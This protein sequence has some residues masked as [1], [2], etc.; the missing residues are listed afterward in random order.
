MLISILLGTLYG[1]LVGIVPAVG[2]TVGLSLLFGFVS[3][4]Q[5][6]P[7]Q[8]LAFITAAVAASTTADSYSSILIGVPGANSSAATVIDGYAMTKKGEG[9]RAFTAAV[10]TSTLSGVLVGIATFMLLPYF[11][12]L[13]EHISSFIIWIVLMSSVTCIAFLSSKSW[14]KNITV[15]I[16]AFIVGYIGI[17]PITN[18]NRWTFGWD[19]LA[20]GIQLLPVVMGLFAIPEC[21]ELYKTRQR[22]TNENL[23]SQIFIGMK[24]IFIHWKDAVR[25]S[26]IGATIG[27]I[28]G[29][30][31]AV[32]DWISYS[33]T[34]ASNKNDEFGNGNVKGVIGIEGSNNAQKATSLVPTLLFGIPG[35]SFA[36]IYLALLTFIGFEIG[37]DTILYDEEFMNTILLSFI[38]ATLIIGIVS[39][40]LLKPIQILLSIDQR[41]IAVFVLLVC[42][43]TAGTYTG[44]ME[45]YVMLS[46]FSILGCIMKK[47]KMPR[48]AFL[49]A[50]ILFP[51]IE[52]YTVVISSL[53]FS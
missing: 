10:L 34:I 3:L 48:P 53:Y 44:G 28:P 29:V 19:Y 11:S 9:I 21:I 18:A 25:G 15:I 24:D 47:Y 27:I 52:I 37:T 45:D 51:K 2:A 16:L 41:W 26:F 7:Y 14:W 23:N 12:F 50:F 49:I 6:E 40:I 35:A 30:G 22:K 36:A 39:F 20:D 1:L 13:I 32:S 38:A 43:Y 4:L 17:D 33:A 46:I 5:I 42:L 8:S 31:G